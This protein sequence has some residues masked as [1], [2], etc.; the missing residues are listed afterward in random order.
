MNK[1]YLAWVNVGAGCSWSRY[2]TRSGAVQ[3]AVNLLRDWE[4]LYDVWD[5]EV[6][7]HSIEVTGYGD[8][9]WDYEGVFGVPE[10]SKDDK[11]VKIDRPVEHEKR[12]TKP[13]PGSN[14]RKIAAGYGGTGNEFKR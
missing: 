14:K 11:Y 9:T 3:I 10:G 12:R 2:P 8:L 1:E 4:K 7:V 13:K 6:T 5:K